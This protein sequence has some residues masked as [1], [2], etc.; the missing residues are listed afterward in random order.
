MELRDRGVSIVYI[1]H[2]MDEV[3]RIADDI[4]VIRDG[5]L[6]ATHPVQELTIDQVITMMVGR[7]LDSQYPKETCP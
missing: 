7:K 3:F 2:K 1:S 5:A 6:I 4:T